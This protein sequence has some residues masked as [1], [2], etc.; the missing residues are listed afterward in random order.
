M[1][2]VLRLVKF[3]TLVD[4]IVICACHVCLRGVETSNRSSS[5]HM[6][7]HSDTY[8]NEIK[9]LRNV[10]NEW[11]DKSAAVP[12]DLF[13]PFWQSAPVMEHHKS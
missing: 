9:P 12:I 13:D 8:K 5:G 4:K 11:E 7:A 3:L 6:C 10:T 2:C 1:K